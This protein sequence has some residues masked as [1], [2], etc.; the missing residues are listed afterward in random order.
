[1]VKCGINPCCHSFLAVES[2]TNWSN[3]LSLS[4]L[5]LKLGLEPAHI[6]EIQVD[7]RNNVLQETYY[8]VR[9]A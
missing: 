7:F 1:M 2:W 8:T 6:P 4:F 9:G 3:S 5:T